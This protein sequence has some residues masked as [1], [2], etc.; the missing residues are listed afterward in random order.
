MA[1]PTPLKATAGLPYSNQVRL[2]EGKTIWE[3]LEEFE[4]RMHIRVNEDATSPLKY[5]FTPHLVPAFDNNDIVVS[6]ELS[7]SETRLLKSGYYGLTISDEG[8]TDDRAIQLLHGP[9]DLGSVTT[10]P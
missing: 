2:L 3:T 9:F 4:V 10:G 8:P 6:W 5:D 1:P 7:G